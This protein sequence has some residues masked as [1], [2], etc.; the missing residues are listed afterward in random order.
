MSREP[1]A[2]SRLVWPLALFSLALAPRLPGLR[3]FLTTD[4]PFFADQA[5]NVVTALLRGDFG[6]TYWHFYP[7][8]TM[9]WLDGLGVAAQWGLESVRGVAAEPFTQFIR[10]DIL[11]LLVALRLPYTLLS[12]LFVVALYL[13]VRRLSDQRVALLAALLVAFDPFFLAHSRVAHGDGPVTVFLGVAVL[14]FAL[15]LQRGAAGPIADP[16]SARNNA[17]SGWLVLSAICGGLAALTK[18][19]GPVILPFVILLGLGDWAVAGARLA[20]GRLGA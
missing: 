14:A 9:S 19:P 2:V 8:L 5:A 18:S 11:E 4:E 12:A 13:L 1:S 10:R 16:R 7:G 15:H 6:A 20:L 17:V 3:L